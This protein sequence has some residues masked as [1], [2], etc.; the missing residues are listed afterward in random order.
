MKTGKIF[1]KLQEK[2]NLSK[3]EKHKKEVNLLVNTDGLKKHIDAY[4]QIALAK[5][6][7]ANYARKNTVNIDI[8]D[9]SATMENSKHITPELAKSADDYIT[10]RV[11]DTLTGKAKDTIIPADTKQTY[12]YTRR[13]TRV[14]EN[15]EAGIEYIHHGYISHEDNF[16]R[17]L[18]RNISNLTD[19]IKG[20]NS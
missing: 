7:I 13:N 1:N 5:E 12:I 19:A 4:N 14:L 11:N 6:T 17:M 16:L 15:R 8:F 10:I 3:Y 18:Y 20:K 9:T 2:I